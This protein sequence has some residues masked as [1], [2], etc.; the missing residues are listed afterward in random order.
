MIGPRIKSM[1]VISLLALAA[2]G[3]EPM[4]VALVEDPGPQSLYDPYA[5][6]DGDTFVGDILVNSQTDL[7]QFTDYKRIN[8]HVTIGSEYLSELKWNKLQKIDGNLFVWENPSL[9]NIELSSLREV[10]GTLLIRENNRLTEASFPALE[11]IGGTL[12]IVY[13]QSL[14]DC[15]VEDLTT[16]IGS[17]NV[18]EG[19]FVQGNY[20][21]PGC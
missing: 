3:A 6:S 5:I 9:E 1:A 11:K 15:V 21:D 13:N 20:D 18:A 12:S 8:G 14:S 7:D 10:G 16:E 19:V 4:P 2:C 17:A